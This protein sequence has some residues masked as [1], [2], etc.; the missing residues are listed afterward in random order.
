MVFG[1]LTNGRVR[2][3]PSLEFGVDPKGLPEGALSYTVKNASRLYIS[4]DGEGENETTMEKALKYNQQ[5]RCK[6]YYNDRDKEKP[7]YVD[8]PD[9]HSHSWLS[10]TEYEMLIDEMKK[11]EDEDV[12]VGVDYL[13]VLDLMKSLENNGMKTR[14]IFWFDN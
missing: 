1:Y 9:F 8:H 12:Y 2:Y 13:A 5:Y 4:E 7:V 11:N 3:E 14:F 10:L 6:L